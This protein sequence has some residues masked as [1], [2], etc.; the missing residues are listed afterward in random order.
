MKRRANCWATLSLIS[1]TL[2]GCAGPGLTTGRDAYLKS[3]KPYLAYWQKEGM[4]EEGRLKDWVA[5]GGMKD[6][7]F[8]YPLDPNARLS[9]ESEQEFM[10]RLDHAFQ[11]CMIRSD[12]HY[13]GN[14]SS[15]YMKAR[16][17]CGAPLKRA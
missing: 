1:L 10:T 16:P 9:G 15:E 14:C 5:C 12:Y 17:L 7:G 3:I 4:T 11:R 2:A 6:G 8:G 13:T